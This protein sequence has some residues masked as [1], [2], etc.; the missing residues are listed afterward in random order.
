[1]CKQEMNRGL[2]DFLLYCMVMDV[3]KQVDQQHSC[4][5]QV[6][7]HLWALH[8]ADKGVWSGELAPSA[9]ATALAVVALTDTGHPADPALVRAG[10]HWLACDAHADGGW[11]DTP[12]SPSNLSTTLL[13]YAAIQ[14]SG[15][16]QFEAVLLRAEKKLKEELKTLISPHSV[17]C[18]LRKQYG[19]DRTFAVPIQCFLA[20]CWDTPQAWFQ[21]MPLPFALALLPQRLYRFLRLQVVSYAL[22]ALIA[23]GLCR[24]LHV[25]QL[26]R[27]L[28]WGRWIAK[29][30]LKR[31]EA[32]QPAHGG[33]LD[34]IPLTAF[35]VLALRQSGFS[36]HAVVRKGLAFLRQ[37]ARPQGCWPIDSN[38]SVW[39]TS[40]AARA[41]ARSVTCGQEHVSTEA[42]TRIAKGVLATQK[43]SKHPFTGAAPGGWAWTDLPGG[44]PDADDTAGA[45]VALYRL[46]DAGCRV[47]LTETVWEGLRWLL[48]LQNRDGGM[49]TFC[50][51]WGPL[52]FDRSCP[53]ISAHALAACSL[54]AKVIVSQAD[55]QRE[56]RL[57]AGVRKLCCYLQQTQ[58]Q[59]GS[60]EPLWFGNQE[61]PGSRNPV[62]GTA[63]VVDALRTVCDLPS[64]WLE[65]SALCD[66]SKMT[67]AGE[68]WLV[69]AQHADGGW[70]A[71][72]IA[73]VE[74]TALAVIALCGGSNVYRA[75]VQRG[76]DWLEEKWRSGPP[77]A[78][79]IGLYFSRLWYHERLY[80]LVWSLEALTIKMLP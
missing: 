51:G 80:P 43:R 50:R 72:A 15:D 70:G 77:Q 56:R 31:L 48:D 62:V 67:T 24:H 53:D 27:R 40:L 12:E 6:F 4:R 42:L 45:L 33:Y 69:R 17:M 34:A 14:K 3:K 21:V 23:V 73:T 2:H 41:V 19:R 75:A 47:A 1:M 20:M 26:K 65:S 13:V 32:L 74:E 39:V 57:C 10:L 60:W 22:P 16:K 68:Q 78:A 28:A 49:A 11:G 46:Q 5:A 8:D 58:G 35:V 66:V 63:R 7:E 38:L 61:S 59:D 25:A 36:E 76:Q 44:V 37:T 71:G 30:L 9:L 29:P 55:K 64:T 79:P 54:W 18:A 52:P